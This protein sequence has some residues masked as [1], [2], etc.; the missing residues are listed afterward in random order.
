MGRIASIDFGL[1]RIGLAVSD[2]GKI[3]ATAQGMVLAERSSALTIKRVLEALSSFELE[4]I[5]VGLPLHLNGKTGFLAD[6][7]LHFVGLLEKVAPCPVVTFDERFSTAQAER[8]LREGN[9]S[10]KKRSKVIDSLSAVI[11]LQNY[12]DSISEKSYF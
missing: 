5:V 8:T 3:I 4:M 9:M 2:E 7:V 11:V 1:K 6:E 12:L 10:R